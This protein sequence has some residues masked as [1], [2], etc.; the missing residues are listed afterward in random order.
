[1]V[2]N[3][4]LA[5]LLDLSIARSSSETWYLRSM[6]KLQSARLHKEV[7]KAGTKKYRDTNDDDAVKYRI[8]RRDQ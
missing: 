7:V 1:M 8:K 6:P 2:T 3:V 5:E 4:E